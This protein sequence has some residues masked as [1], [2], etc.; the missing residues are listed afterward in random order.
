MTGPGIAAGYWTSD[1]VRHD[2]MLGER[3]VAADCVH[4]GWYRDRYRNSGNRFESDSDSDPDTE[5]SCLSLY[6]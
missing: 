1:G 2:G 3:K 4:R 5:I 6:F